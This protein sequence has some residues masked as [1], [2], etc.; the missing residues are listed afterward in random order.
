MT[1]TYHKKEEKSIDPLDPQTVFTIKHSEIPK[2]ITQCQKHEWVKHSE[3]EI[4]CLK[5]PT[6]N[7]ID[8]KE[9]KKY[10]NS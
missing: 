10:V 4:R 9:M 6:V 1:N 8:P 7:I 2:G 5:C 3:N